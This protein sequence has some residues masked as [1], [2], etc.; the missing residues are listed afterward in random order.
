MQ[1]GF[2]LSAGHGSML[3]YSILHIAGYAISIEDIKNFRQLGSPCQG[4][5]EYGSAEG[6]EM[7]TGP[8]GQG[9]ATAVGMAIAEK[10]LSS[11]FNTEKYK[12]FDH[13][14]YVLLGEGC[15]MEG[16]SHESCSLAG[17]L[18]LNKLIVYYDANK[19]SIDGKTDITFLED[20]RLR[21]LSYGW[22]VLHGNMYSYRDIF[23][24]TEK[25]KKSDKPTLII[26]DSIIGCG[27]PTVANTAKAHGAPLGADGVKKAKIELGI[28]SEEEFFVCKEA[29]DFFKERQ[30]EYSK[31]EE[32]WKKNFALWAK[33][34]PEKKALF[35]FYF[36]STSKNNES[37]TSLIEKSLSALAPNHYDTPIATR[38]AS[39]DVLTKLKEILPNL[40]GGSA[41]LTSPNAVGVG[42]KVFDKNDSSGRY[43][44]YGVRELAMASITN[45]IALHG[46]LI[47]FCATFLVFCDYMR[48]S[49]RLASLMETPSIYVFTHDSIFVGEDGATHQP[50][51][52]LASLRAIPNLLVLRAGDA[53]EVALAWKIALENK[54]GP[55]A[56]ILSRQALPIYKKDDANWQTNIYNGAYIVKDVKGKDVKTTIIATGSE[57]A[58]ALDAIKMLKNDTDVR[59]VSM[60]SKEKFSFQSQNYKDMILG[61]NARIITVEA[62]VRQGWES[63][64]KD[65]EDNFSIEKFG[66]SAPGKDVARHLGFTAEKLAKLIEK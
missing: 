29:Y 20:V 19:V 14:T 43:I 63:F 37:A 12:I 36:D 57:V 53:E 18:A 66:T 5:P 28:D 41:D 62:G 56:I 15:L 25:A 46:G 59:I 49:I 54:D 61:K 51:E 65:I 34:N 7:T 27:A 35:D 64:V 55:S 33:E 21:F 50:I 3:L 24:L 6:V 1:I 2:I 60:I 58:L 30:K 23:T 16:I 48:P 10:M 26:L 13:Y 9:I 40:V 17:T 11:T 42:L 22:N 39:K 45:G 44:H 52:T 47:P 4:H 38:A 8:L 32:E 31:V